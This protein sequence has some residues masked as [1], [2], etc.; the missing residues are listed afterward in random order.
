MKTKTRIFLLLLLAVF[1]YK[2]YSQGSALVI[3]SE[4]GEKFTVFMNGEMKNSKPGDYVRV[5]NLFGPS[6]KVRVVFADPAIH[7]IDKTVF[8]KIGGEIFYAA[9]PGKKGDYVLEHATSD[10]VHQGNAV[11]ESIPEKSVPQETHQKKTEETTESA[12]KSS[13]G[14]CKNPMTE[15]DFQASIVMISNAP[16]DGPKTSSAKKLVEGHC[17]TCDQIVETMYLVSHEPSRLTIAKAAYMH[18]FDPSNYEKVKNV[19]E[20]SKSKQD[21]DQYIESVK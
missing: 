3:F 15:P 9:K 18:C 20:T 12:G 5:D 1:S 7:E 4:K 14:G 21:L 10:Y 19:L 8:N 11:K 13:K 6:F 2:V 17:L 16:F